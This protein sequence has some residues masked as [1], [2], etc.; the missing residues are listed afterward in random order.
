MTNANDFGHLEVSVEFPQ[1]SQPC[2]Y[3]LKIFIDS[4]IKP[5]SLLK[6]CVRAYILGGTLHTIHNEL[7][8]LGILEF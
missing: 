2:V 8:K 4:T 5:L 1:T 3:F 6:E 7:L